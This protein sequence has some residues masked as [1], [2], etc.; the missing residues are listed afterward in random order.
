MKA[1]VFNVIVQPGKLD[2]L[3]VGV[4][5]VVQ[6]AA[7]QQPGFKNA[8]LLTDSSTNKAIYISFWET[9]ADLMASEANGYVREQ[10]AKVMPLL[11]AAPVQEIYEVS[12]QE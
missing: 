5:E 7:K 4:H 10:L 11:I 8:L 2:E 9:E 12:V 6:T 3:T 1:R